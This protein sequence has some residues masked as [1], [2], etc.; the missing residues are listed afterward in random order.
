[1]AQSNFFANISCTGACAINFYAT[2]LY[3]RGNVIKN[4][5]AA[6]YIL[7]RL[8]TPGKPLQPSL[9]FVGK[10]SRVSYSGDPDWCF[11]W[12]GSSLTHTR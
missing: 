10:A 12:V 11:T 5:V 4:F 1:M 7:P 6:I 9:V 3:T 2:V 8:F